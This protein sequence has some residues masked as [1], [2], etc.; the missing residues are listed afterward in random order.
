[1]ATELFIVVRFSGVLERIQRVD[2]A[3]VTIGRLLDNV[4]CLT[5][6]AVSRHHA[7]LTRTATQCGIRDLG[8]RNGTL[9]NGHAIVEA[10]L[11]IPALV[12]IGPYELKVFGELRYAELEAKADEGSTRNEFLR[13]KSAYER[14]QREESLTP[15]QHRV[16]NELLCGRTEKEAANVLNISIH[17][18]HT[19]SRAIYTKFGVSSR[20][21]LLSL[22][23][24]PQ[25]PHPTQV[26]PHVGPAERPVS[27][28]PKHDP[29]QP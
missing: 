7:V 8:S 22:A 11:T 17:T 15:A 19:H 1:M 27:G 9:M 6:A 5:D 2:V 26:M 12:E 3:E 21:E 13:A 18:V 4:L 29:V 25:A 20:G 16:Y 10:E 23:A 14:R 24:S 28:S